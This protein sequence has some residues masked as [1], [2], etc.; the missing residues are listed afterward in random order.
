[1]PII[2]ISG[3][4]VCTFAKVNWIKKNKYVL[5][6]VKILLL[7]VLCYFI[8]SQLK[9]YSNTV[10]TFSLENISLLFYKSKFALL[11][12]ILLMPINWFV[13]AIKWK[14]IC[15][16]HQLEVSISDAYASVFFGACAGF[17]SPGRWGEPLARAYYV[18]R[19]KISQKFSLS[20][21][22]IISQWIITIVFAMI[23]ILGN[24]YSN[25]FLVLSIGLLAFFIILFLFYEKVYNL[26]ATKI[27]FL[28]R[29]KVDASSI[30]DKMI[31]FFYTLL[32]YSIYT[33]QYIILISL[34]IKEDK[35]IASIQSTF[36]LFFYQSFSPLP[37][38][39]DYAFKNNIALYVYKNLQINSI[40]ILF[41][42]F[43]I[44]L[45]NLVIPSIVGYVLFSKKINEF[46]NSK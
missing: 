1:M 44:W 18:G 11:L 19:E 6:I 28:Q 24:Y 22:G 33:I 30:K 43:I 31:V 14:Y 13:E 2:I 32:R 41:V 12:V 8:Y 35:L 3:F 36:L 42:I 16:K 10:S 39:V 29:Y 27:S 37:G 46:W 17:V 5:S 25:N 20:L 9:N 40:E 45:V 7:I 38:V 34:F 26:L 23:A 4:V 21:I 15:K